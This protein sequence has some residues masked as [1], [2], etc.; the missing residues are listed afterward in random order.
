M[1]TEE[2]EN[3]TP[4]G[5]LIGFPKEIISRMLD[6]QVEQDNPRDVSV[7]EKDRTAGKIAKG[8]FLSDTEEGYN[9]WNEVIKEKNFN[10]FF[11]KYPKQNNQDNLQEFR[12]GDKVIDIITG[13]IGKVTEIHNP[14]P[15]YVDFNEKTLESYLLD[16]R[17]YSNDK[18]PRLLHYRD[19]Y[20]Y[21]IINFNNL[22]QKQEPKRWRAEEGEYYYF[23]KRDDYD[24]KLD[25]VCK[26]TDNYGYIFN[27]QYK[28]GNYFKTKE[29]AEIIVQKLNTYFK[30]LIQEEHE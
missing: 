17:D 23:I 11:E 16:G 14:F 25:R 3:Y 4:K 27:E 8:F 24:T 10:V 20:N 1:N 2:L 21:D 9:F 29:E 22:P 12:V 7:F 5:D 18:Y 30:Q 13:Q 6:C 19:D 15:I 26:T 28:I